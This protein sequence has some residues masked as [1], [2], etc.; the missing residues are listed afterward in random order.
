MK[1]E[2]AGVP[3][4]EFV[5]FKPKMYYFLGDDNN[6]HRK[7]KG[8]NKNVVAEKSH[9][10]YKNALLCDKCLR[11][12]MNRIQSKNNTTGTYEI[13]ISLSCFVDK[14]YII[15]NGYDGLAFGY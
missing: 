10:K 11:H 2:T 5:R 14:I 6:E 1:D 4:K 9:N 15:Y 8:V 12:S 7:A 13:Y 3:I